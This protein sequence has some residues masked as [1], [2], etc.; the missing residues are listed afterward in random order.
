MKEHCDL[1]LEYKDDC[2][3]RQRGYSK[4]IPIIV[5]LCPECRKEVNRIDRECRKEKKRTP[6]IQPDNPSS[7]GE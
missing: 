6:T 4:G 5:N 1:C 2:R 7:L 3:E